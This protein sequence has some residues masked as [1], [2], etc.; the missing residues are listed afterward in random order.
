MVVTYGQI[1]LNL[2]IILLFLLIQI[3]VR[4]CQKVERLYTGYKA[5]NLV[6]SGSGR[7]KELMLR[8]LLLHGVTNL[9]L[10]KS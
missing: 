2:Y 6:R 7:P 8:W 1:N 3:S 4:Y 10:L 5:R 9:V